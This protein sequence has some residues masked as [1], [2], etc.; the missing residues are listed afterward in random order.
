MVARFRQAKW[1]SMLADGG[2]CIAQSI[3]TREPAGLSSMEKNWSSTNGKNYNA[4]TKTIVMGGATR[5][6]RLYQAC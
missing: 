2:V 4:Q 1:S 5:N 3:P 6:G